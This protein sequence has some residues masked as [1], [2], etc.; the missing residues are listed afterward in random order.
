M[1]PAYL[2]FYENRVYFVNENLLYE[3]QVDTGEMVWHE[4]PHT[5]AYNLS[6]KGDKLYIGCTDIFEGTISYL[7][8]FD[9]KS[10]EIEQLLTTDGCILQVEVSGEDKNIIYLRTY[11][12]IE[13]YKMKNNE[14]VKEQE[15]RLPDEKDYFIGG[16]FC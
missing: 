3:Y 6:L 10:G 5:N 11:E 15:L 7:D 9:T 14:V 8:V 4:L 16:F 2:E 13:K 12:K 1:S